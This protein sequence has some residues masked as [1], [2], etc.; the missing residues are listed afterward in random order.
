M[1]MGIGNAMNDREWKVLHIFVVTNTDQ[2]IYIILLNDNEM[3][4]RDLVSSRR[5]SSKNCTR[6]NSL[7]PFKY[8]WRIKS[9]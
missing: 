1:L 9:K 6:K 3:E 4:F 2:E 7:R 5:F 8:D